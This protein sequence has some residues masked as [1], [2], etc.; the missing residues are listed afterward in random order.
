MAQAPVGYEKPPVFSASQILPDTMLMGPQHRVRDYAPSDGFLI[1]FTMDTNFGVIEARGLEELAVRV[2]EM[3]A[4]QL[5]VETSKSDLFAEGLK[6]S[7]EAPIDAVKNIADDPKESFKKAPATI[8]HFFQKVGSSITN[9]ADKVE[10]KWEKRDESELDVAEA[11]RGIGNAAKGVVGFEK[12]K[13]DCAR[14]LGVNPYSDN[15]LLQKQMDEVTWAF[16][17]GG[18]PLRLGASAVSGGASMALSATKAVGIP[19]E[20]YDVTPSELALRDRNAMEQMGAGVAL[21]EQ[22][23]LN[24][25][26]NTGLRHAVIKALTE[27]PGGIDRVNVL[28]QAAS[29]ATP[30]Q[31]RYFYQ[32]LVK[33]GERHKVE[34]YAALTTVGRM[35]AA[36]TK[37]G[38]LEVVAPVDYLSWTPQIAQF[39]STPKMPQRKY[40]V[41]IYGKIST[42]A[43]E[44][45]KRSGWELIDL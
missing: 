36:I 27:L 2:H 41:V 4:I 10:D 28:G 22:V 13:L 9:A 23:F 24:P 35:P 29:C 15:Q 7:L 17:A 14:K 39:A 42:L 34:A 32:V 40:R 26:L 21:I 6:R 43:I 8:G 5:L 1:H 16:F 37:D 31:A 44:G 18:L 25:N 19:E 3:D 38:V 45:F 20:L 11:G 30:E 12:A 33:L